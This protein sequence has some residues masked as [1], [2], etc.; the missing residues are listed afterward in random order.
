MVQRLACLM[1][2]LAFPGIPTGALEILLNITPLEEFFLAEAVRGSYKI[3]VS[4]L[5][6]MSTELVSLGKRKAMLMF[7]IRQE[8]SY[9]CC[10]CQLTE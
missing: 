3:T 7:A 9:L 8:D 2:S 5:W 4:R 1:I 10:K 6:H